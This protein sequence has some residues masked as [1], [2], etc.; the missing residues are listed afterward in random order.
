M[1][2]Q[3]DAGQI[4]HRDA[5]SIL[6]ASDRSWRF[7]DLQTIRIVGPAESESKLD[8]FSQMAAKQQ[9]KSKAVS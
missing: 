3:W 9:D 7:S 5:R 6:G 8:S 4:R 2:P 1:G